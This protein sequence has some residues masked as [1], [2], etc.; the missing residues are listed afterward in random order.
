MAFTVANIFYVAISALT[1]VGAFLLQLYFFKTRPA[2][3]LKD[4]PSSFFPLDALA[5]RSRFRNFAYLYAL[6]FAL[7]YFLVA[8]QS[9][10]FVETAKDLIDTYML[11]LISDQ[12]IKTTAQAFLHAVPKFLNPLFIFFA[13]GLLFAPFLRAPMLLFRSLVL[14]AMGLEAR[15]DQMAK[16]AANAILKQNELR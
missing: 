10:P 11:S 8:L 16:D 9:R 7:L 4:R 6:P 2:M 12:S 13:T 14:F 1:T 3:R 5:S 15:A